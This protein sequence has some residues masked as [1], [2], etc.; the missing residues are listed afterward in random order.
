MK[1]FAK[2]AVIALLTAVVGMVACDDPVPNGPV[3][4]GNDDPSKVESPLEG[5]SIKVKLTSTSIEEATVQVNFNVVNELSYLVVEADLTNAEVAARVAGKTPTAEEIFEN[6]TPI[7]I[8]KDQ[9][10]VRL[11]VT[12]LK[13]DTGYVI[14]VAGRLVKD[15]QVYVYEKVESV[16]VLTYAQPVL[17][18][19]VTS[20][21]TTAVKF[22][23]TSNRISK[24][25]YLIYR[26]KEAPEAAPSADII[27]AT[28]KMGV[29]ESAQTDVVI[30]ALMPNNDYII[31]IAGEVEE[32][33]EY[34]DEIVVLDGIKTQDF[35]EAYKVHSIDY[36]SFKVDLKL[37]DSIAEL[38]HILK[39]GMWDLYAFNLNHKFGKNGRPESWAQSINLHESYYPNQIRESQTLTFDN[40]SAWVQDEYG[41]PLYDEEYQ[42]YRQIHSILVP[43]Q[44]NML[45]IG[46]YKYGDHDVYANFTGGYYQPLFLS[47]DY[48]MA[49]AEDVEVSQNQ[50]P[51]WYGFA[52]QELVTTKQ[53]EP[54]SGKVDFKLLLS[55]DN[56]NTKAKVRFTPS[57]EVE[58]YCVWIITESMRQEILPYLNNDEK[59]L[60]WFVTSESGF[61]EG[62]VG[63]TGAKEMWLGTDP[64]GQGNCFYFVDGALTNSKNVYYAYVVAMGGGDKDGDGICDATLQSFSRTEFKLGER[65]LKDPKV[66]ITVLESEPNKVRFN[67]KK[68]AESSQ[69]KQAYFI[70]NYEREWLGAG[71][72]PETLLDYYGNPLSA[73]EVAM[74]NDKDGYTIEFDSRP[75]TTT[76]F[77]MK[78]YNGESY[79]TYSETA[80][81]TSKVSSATDR[82]ESD[83]FTSLNGDWT[84]KATIS[85][86]TVLDEDTGEIGTVVSEKTSKVTIGEQTYPETL[87]QSVYD[88]FAQHNVSKEATDSYFAELTNAIDLFNEDARNR[89]QVICTG[90]SFDL[91]GET[92]DTYQSAFDLFCSN[93]YNGWS[94]TS[95]LYDFGPKWYIEID[96]DGK[97]WVPFNINNYVPM[98]SWTTTDS[99]YGA[100]INEYHMLAYETQTPSLLPYL[101][102]ETSVFDG[103]FPVEISA[104]GNTITIKPINVG[105]LDY[106]P[107]MGAVYSE[108]YSQ[109]IF[110][111]SI[112]SEIVMTRGWSGSEAQAQKVNT[113]KQVVDNSLEVSPVK[114]T[115]SL[116]DFTTPVTMHEEVAP[117]IIRDVQEYRETTR[118]RVESGFYA[119]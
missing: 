35:G 25:A 5:A 72:P 50:V 117:F 86:K 48:F 109:F 70:A 4:P 113:K 60:Q 59:Y 85:Y 2:L 37:P 39:Y 22:Q 61:S 98:S 116:T 18:A 84:A 90:W 54:F 68:S 76:Y 94:S 58:Q 112:I 107:N 83:Y 79:F 13:P 55:E 53:P 40:N 41:N 106:Y 42:S 27:F 96:A 80:K 38:N 14:Y 88:I 114:R 8:T 104:D 1:K 87:P 97:A 9:A 23:I 28:G 16:S 52:V 65:K 67:I 89:N 31:Y 75:N 43:G 49:W 78:V 92:K 69:I 46:E 102:D 12:D 24:Y 77:K 45:M 30:N 74:I 15:E 64:T 32:L 115:Q 19:T 34:F 103:K 29:V 33:E 91:S 57:E 82:I 6:G 108:D 62:A 21:G 111:S 105:G 73:S 11:T 93:T 66:D 81:A 10:V 17:T 56:N 119:R 51:W 36:A 20:V 110:G 3:D 44:P 99:G 95:P 100:Y 118:K 7:E 63:L 47:D 71:Y 101:W 26:V